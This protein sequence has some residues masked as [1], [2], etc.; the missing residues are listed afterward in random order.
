MTAYDS[1]VP[2]DYDKIN[3]TQLLQSKVQAGTGFKGFRHQRGGKGIA[4]VIKRL[5]QSI[6]AFYKSPIGRE[7]TTSLGSIAS[8]ISSGEPPLKSFKKAG[9]QAIRNLTGLGKRKR[10][11]T[12]FLP[13]A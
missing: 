13:A 2:F 5:R 10:H 8:D 3:F 6:P 11:Q 4:N 1:S 9:R 12:V 7:V